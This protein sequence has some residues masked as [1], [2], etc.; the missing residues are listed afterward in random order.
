MISTAR[1]VR[2]GLKTSMEINVTTIVNNAISACG[3]AWL[4]IC[5]KVSVS[6]V[7]RLMIDPFVF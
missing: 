6:F 7:Y 1:I 3:I 2:S 5:L 4:I